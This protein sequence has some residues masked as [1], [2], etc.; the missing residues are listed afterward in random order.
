[1]I[2]Y[3]VTWMSSE[4]AATLYTAEEFADWA[5]HSG[6]FD[7]INYVSRWIQNDDGTWMV[8]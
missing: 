3:V 6:A 8:D 7:E 4:D 1:M 5:A 2:V